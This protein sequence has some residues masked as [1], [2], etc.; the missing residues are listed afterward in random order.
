MV[1]F[2]SVELSS[3]ANGDVIFTSC[4]NDELARK[5]LWLVSASSRNDLAREGSELIMDVLAGNLDNELTCVV[6]VSFTTDLNCEDL[7][8]S[9][10]NPNDATV[11]GS[12][13][14][15]TTFFSVGNKLKLRDD[16]EI[17]C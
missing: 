1:S 2:N 17:T 7:G 10:C 3:E 6:I 9:I 4:L 16:D 8:D 14:M 13:L 15:V 12:V 5:P 11:T